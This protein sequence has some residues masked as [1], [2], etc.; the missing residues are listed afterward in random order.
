MGFP[1]YKDLGVRLDQVQTAAEVSD[2]TLGKEP[3]KGHVLG[4]RVSTDVGD[5]FVWVQANGAVAAGVVVAMAAGYDV[6]PLSGAGQAF[7]VSTVAIADNG[8]GFVQVKGKVT[9]APAGTSVALGD[10]L[11]RRTDSSGDLILSANP[12]T[13]ALAGDADI[14]AIALAADTAGVAPIYIY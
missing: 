6:A 2:T 13:S 4:L 14:F 9:S 7:G 3:S 8:Q 12:D 10:A 5:E 11:A 1:G